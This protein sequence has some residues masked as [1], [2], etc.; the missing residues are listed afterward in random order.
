MKSQ[1][2]NLLG[3]APLVNVSL[4][5]ATLERA[6][7]RP[8]HLPGIVTFTGPSGYGKSTAAAIAANRFGAVYVQAKST[9][10]RKAAHLAI[11]KEMGVA[12]ARTLNAMADQVAEQLALS[13]RPLILD[14]CDYLLKN[15]IIEIVRDMYEASNA[16]IMVIGEEHL[17]TNLRQWERFHGRILKFALAEPASLDDARYL[18]DLYVDDVQIDD[19]LLAR[20]HQAAKGSVR[21]ICV[22][23]AHIREEA[24]DNGLT[25][26]DA[27]YWGDRP[28]FTGDAPR[29]S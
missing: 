16:A 7:N 5:V 12:P 13:G 20:V 6:I 17:P 3:K 9:W 19:S 24:H 2:L 23:L 21:R 29:R 15:S 18:R 25:S 26:I 14:E 28:L 11:L 27:T 1:P 10:T 4:C 22:N 8:A